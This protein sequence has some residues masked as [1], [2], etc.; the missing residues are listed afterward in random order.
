MAAVSAEKKEL[1]ENTPIPRALAS[2]A[3]PIII[4]QIINLVYNIADAFFIGRAGNSYMMAS[5]TLS[6]TLVMMTLAISNL[7]G[8]GAGS[9]IARL[10][11]ANRPDEAKKVCSYGFYGALFM[12]L[13]YSAL[14]GVFMRP[15]LMLLGGSD[16]T[17]GFAVQYVF[18]VI[19]L[20][21]VPNVMSSTV[22]NF[23]MNVG[24]SKQ[25]STGFAIGAIL[26]IFLDPLFMFVILPRGYEVLG[27]A[28]ATMLSN[29]VAMVYQL[30]N[31]RKAA[32][33]SP[34]G[35]RLSDAR[36]AEK[37]SVRMVYSVGV[38]SATLTVLYDIAN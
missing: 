7:Y 23:L 25:A 31:F 38:P 10:I 13:L 9:Q 27:A 11:G 6:L 16:A 14:V 26:N 36:T 17:I 28:I 1:F 32:K 12:S 21:T 29:V 37:D 19:V 20:G 30:Y 2:M 24:F 8:V 18:F 22:A 33:M 4:S 15:I 34:L 35:L 5:T 3:V